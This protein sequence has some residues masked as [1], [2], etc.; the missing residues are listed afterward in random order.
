MAVALFHKG[1]G[2][3]HG[4]IQPQTVWVSPRFE[5]VCLNNFPLFP[6]GHLLL[7]KV[8]QGSQYSGPLSPEDLAT[9][10]VS[11]E[12]ASEVWS[13]GMT[14]LC[15]ATRKLLAEFYDFQQLSIK[16]WAVDAAVLSL[17]QTGSYS[18]SLVHAVISMLHREPKKRA[19]AEQVQT[20]IDMYDD[21]AEDES[22]SHLESLCISA[23]VPGQA[24]V[25]GPAEAFAQPDWSGQRGQDLDR[26][27]DLPRPSNR[28][29]E[30]IRDR[31][32]S[33]TGLET[34]PA[35]P[36]FSQHPA[37]ANPLNAKLAFKPT[38]AIASVQ[39]QKSKPSVVFLPEKVRSTPQQT[40]PPT[41]P[42]A[43]QQS[44][45]SS[46]SSCPILVSI[47]NMSFV[48]RV[49]QE[50]SHHSPETLAVGSQP[51]KTKPLPRPRTDASNPKP[52]QGRFGQQAGHPSGY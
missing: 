5:V 26:A 43:S 6:N 33:R 34:D 21:E 18:P 19:K 32:Q 35:F 15:F 30:K 11:D 36:A 51:P 37:P 48:L 17:S 28:L 1:K 4:D 45:T 2:R 22:G 50:S 41:P 23:I 3:S 24:F 12:F 42:Q 46:K 10:A 14:V 49:P 25:P 7:N 16:A 47:E 40:I 38:P 39:P 8:L 27:A 52:G 29:F 31:Q 44:F 9:R 13:I 20:I